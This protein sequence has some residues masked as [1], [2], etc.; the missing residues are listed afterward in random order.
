MRI[1]HAFRAYGKVWRVRWWHDRERG[2][3]SFNPRIHHSHIDEG[4]RVITLHPDLRG[5]PRRA[6]EAFV[7]ELMHLV[8]FEERKRSGRSKYRIPH[9]V[10]Y[11]L[12]G[13]LAF[14]LMQMGV[15]FRCVC[16]RCGP[17]AARRRS[18]ARAEFAKPRPVGRIA[19]MSAVRTQ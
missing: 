6:F 9:D 11:H 14:A 7:H 1:P 2:F 4:T 19:A 13:P 18:E 3:P 17:R 10:I 15:S 12:D 16:E 5:H 8:N